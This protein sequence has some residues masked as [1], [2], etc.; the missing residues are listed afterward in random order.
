MKFLVNFSFVTG[1]FVVGCAFAFL[2]TSLGAAFN[3]G[4][5][6][7]GMGLI[8]VALALVAAFLTLMDTI[9]G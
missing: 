7:L 4:S 3:A 5:I 8:I 2:L 1:L 6:A 9:L